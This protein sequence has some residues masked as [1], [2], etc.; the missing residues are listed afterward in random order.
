MFAIGVFTGFTLAQ[1]GMVQHW[2]TTRP[3]GWQ[4]RAL[5]NGLGSC[6][7]G[8]ATV[9]F[10]VTKFSS[11]AWVVLIAV[12]CFIVL[13]VRIN[14]YYRRVR[15]DLG[16]GTVPPKPHARATFVVVPV[17]GVNK[18]TARALSEALSIGG[19]VLAVSV[20][21]DEEGADE[22]DEALRAEWTRWD[23]GVPLRVLRT[24][25]ASVARPIVELIDELRKRSESQIVVLLP[26]V[27]PDRRRYAVLHNHIDTVVASALRSR[28]DVLVTRVVMGLHSL[29]QEPVARGGRE[30]EQARGDAR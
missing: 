1:A 2:R 17:T 11:G 20:L 27:R 22:K 29:I 24:E 7:T 5:L 3:P 23:P 6:V 15:E 30:D 14:H 16:F 9:I 21:Q 12:P 4:P 28:E 19:D 8:I 18:L 25:Y 13:F 10:I 26:V